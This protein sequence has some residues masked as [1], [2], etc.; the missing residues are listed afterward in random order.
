MLLSVAKSDLVVPSSNNN[1]VLLLAA[2]QFLN[3][4]F[5]QYVCIVFRRCNY[6]LPIG[7][8]NPFV[9]LGA[10]D[11]GTAIRRGNLDVSG[12]FATILLQ[13]KPIIYG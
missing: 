4:D 6:I 11:K 2:P 8:R 13:I 12:Y 5:V 10:N 7:F 3:L 1:S 9:P